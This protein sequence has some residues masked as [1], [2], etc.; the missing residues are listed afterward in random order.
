V[1]KIRSWGF[2]VEE[3]NLPDQGPDALNYY[4]L[5]LQL[6]WRRRVLVKRW[7]L[8]DGK[9]FKGSWG[10]AA[11]PFAQGLGRLKTFFYF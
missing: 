8:K 9:E 7:I 1:N 11:R 10:F 4:E 5:I 3:I 2:V 6:C